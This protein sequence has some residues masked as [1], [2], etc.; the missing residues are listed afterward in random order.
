MH[1]AEGKIR[2]LAHPTGAFEET[3][4]LLDDS[5][6][7]LFGNHRLTRSMVIEDGIAKVL[8]VDSNVTGLKGN[9]AP[10]IL[11]QL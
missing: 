11:S 9:L 6:V 7:P 4:L 8:N 2:L 1:Q 3:D 10:N 5:M